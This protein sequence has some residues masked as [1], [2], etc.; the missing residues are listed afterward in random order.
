[1]D[2]FNVT[3]DTSLVL[4]D[5]AHSHGGLLCAQKVIMWLGR[6]QVSGTCAGFEVRCT[7][8]AVFCR[9]WS[10]EEIEAM[11]APGKVFLGW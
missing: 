9:A 4:S 1:M 6:R 3:W 7:V 2:G 10:L 11:N 8:I 5:D